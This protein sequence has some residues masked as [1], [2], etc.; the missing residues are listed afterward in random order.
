MNTDSLGAYNGTLEAL[1]KLL[2]LVFVHG[3]PARVGRARVEDLWRRRRLEGEGRKVNRGNW[4]KAKCIN[5]W[6]ES[7]SACL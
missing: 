3:K 4:G 1:E 6:G 5:L 2:Y 7:E